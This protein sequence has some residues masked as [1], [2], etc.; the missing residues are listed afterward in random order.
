MKTKIVTEILGF[1][2]IKDVATLP[3][4][5]HLFKKS[6]SRCGVYLLQFSAIEF[7][8]GQ[9]I[10]VVKRFAQH[11]KN[12]NDIVGFTFKPIKQI[13]LN[14]IEKELIRAAEKA[15]LVLTNV[16]YASI[17]VGQ[18]DLDLIVS[19]SD[20]KA[21]IA[22]P[23]YV[24][25]NQKNALIKL[26]DAHFHRFKN[27]FDQFSKHPHYLKIM[28]L[29]SNFINRA[30]PFSKATEYSFWAISC[31][32]STNQKTWPRLICL[33]MAV[34]EILVMGYLKSDNDQLW[35]FVTVA[36]DIL[37]EEF[38]S[39]EA[40]QSKH[41]KIELIERNY[42]DAGQ[43]QITLHAL[44]TDELTRLLESNKVLKAA[45]ILNRRV[46]RKRATIYQKYHCK[47]LANEL[48]A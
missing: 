43:F 7:Y 23:L 39:Y 16:T 24:N 4:I 17:T 38:G 46:M 32:P 2:E 18:T 11:R 31:L 44:K 13:N 35:G 34:M 41:P 19:P 3:S 27:R 29:L 14:E 5:S 40:F 1:P 20:Q 15:G 25:E 33:N 21:W 6:D 12:S 42:K 28:H 48:Q 8:I 9:A 10:E 37:I 36:S 45:A 47:Q 30:V 26:N 22:A